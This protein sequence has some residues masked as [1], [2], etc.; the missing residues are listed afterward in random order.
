MQLHRWYLGSKR[1]HFY[2]GG[3]TR[4]LYVKDLTG[5]VLIIMQQIALW[6]AG[7][8]IFDAGSWAVI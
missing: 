8:L 7:R 6:R 4:I 1:F 2:G 3:P 5:R